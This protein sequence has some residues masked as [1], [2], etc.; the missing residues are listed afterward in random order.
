MKKILG[1]ISLGALLV[2]CSNSKLKE[3]EGV[4]IY[5]HEVRIFQD[6]KNKEN[7]WLYSD[8]NTLESLNKMM[9]ERI[10]EKGVNYPEI[11]LLIK[12]IDEGEATN[13]LAEP[14]DRRLKVIEYK[15]LE[16]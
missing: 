2:S 6:I 7:Y 4:Y 5:G 15:V 9:I 16:N 8:N 1:L 14:G 11:R 13:G 3:Y 12:G 10:G